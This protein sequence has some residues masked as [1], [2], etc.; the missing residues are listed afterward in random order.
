MIDAL[1]PFIYIIGMA[2]S[3]LLVGTAALVAGNAPD[4]ANRPTAL[5]LTGA[6]LTWATLLFIALNPLPARWLQSLSLSVWVL[7]SALSGVLLWFC[8]PPHQD[9]PPAPPPNIF[10][11][12]NGH[13]VTSSRTYRLHGRKRA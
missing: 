8:R 10:P 13:F 5:A 4:N 11:R 6:L 9:E 7:L 3:L 2:G 12:I 1:A